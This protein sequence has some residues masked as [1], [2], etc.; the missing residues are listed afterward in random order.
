MGATAPFLEVGFYSFDVSNLSKMSSREKVTAAVG[1]TL[2]LSSLFFSL[3]SNSAT[4]HPS[5]FFC[6]SSLV[7]FARYP[8]CT[9]PV[10]HRWRPRL[11][12]RGSRVRHQLFHLHSTRVSRS[13]GDG[14]QNR[15]LYTYIGRMYMHTYVL[16]CR[17]VMIL[18]EIRRVHAPV[19]H[20]TFP[21]QLSY[22]VRACRVGVLPAHATTG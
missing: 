17:G 7:S 8:P 21:W 12:H 18:S 15:G 11:H 13:R 9:R 10:R 22:V 3:L 6:F 19:F 16:R 1:G 20:A 14:L 4:L 2:P 5:T